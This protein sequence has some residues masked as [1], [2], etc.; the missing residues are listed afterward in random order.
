MT[1]KNNINIHLVP[2]WLKDALLAID[3]KP[4][5][6]KE[7]QHIAKDILSAKVKHIEDHNL[8]L[9]SRGLRKYQKH[10]PDTLDAFDI[11][12]LIASI[13]DIK[14]ILASSKAS[15]DDGAM[16]SIYI[17]DTPLFTEDIP[18]NQNSTRLIGTYTQ[19]D[20]LLRTIVLIIEP[21]VG[22]SNHKYADVI[23]TLR[24][25]VTS[26]H[27]S[28][29]PDRVPVNNGI[30]NRK[31][32]ELEDF[33][34][35]YVVLSKLAIDYNPNAKNPVIYDKNNE[36]W[37]VESWIKDI[38]VD[39]EVN[40]LLWQ[41]ISASIQSRRSMGRSIWF[42][43]NKGNNGK[44]TL[45]Q[46]IKNMYGERNYASLSVA[47]FREDFLKTSLL[48]AG[49]NIA[50]ENDVDTYI[51]SVRD[52]KATITGDDII[53]NIKHKAPVPFQFKGLNI[54]MLNDLPRT[55]DRSDSLYR[56]LIIVPFIKSFTNN[57]EKKYIK[58]DYIHRKDV[59][60]YVLFKAIN[61]DFDEFIQ[62]QVS[63]E[64]LGE[65][66]TYNDPVL[67]YW[68][69]F[70]D[71]FVWDL[72][73]T[74]F[75]YDLF[76]A[77]YN[78]NNPN[79]KVVGKRGFINQLETIIDKDPEWDSHMSQN[80]SAIRTGN[81]M[82]AD[83]PLISEY[84]LDQHMKNGAPSPWM[85]PHYKAKDPVKRRDFPRKNRYRGIVRR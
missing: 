2:D 45:G 49:V 35:D 24:A 40:T 41:V 39:D 4:K 6:G 75:L 50:D 37:D 73:P 63:L 52:Y 67:E 53:I 82:D 3:T 69:E 60:E 26:K 59:L 78:Q 10:I 46:L 43:S 54:Q 1:E 79:G 66:Q 80:D 76:V 56:R 22:S 5:S 44:G 55:K 28:D 51:D 27:V 20:V 21:S 61:M 15:I 83:E 12:V 36:A 62:P 68:N 70:K 29:D 74:P 8:D 48:T 31:T 77:Y 42:Y 32:K 33:N 11:G 71:Q 84:G 38:A 25:I 7:I 17:D 58:E 85:A 14:L 64:I 16:L 13:L 72:I 9:E 19:S 34:P 65:Y 30:F 23:S 18:S 47:Q 81:L 57:G